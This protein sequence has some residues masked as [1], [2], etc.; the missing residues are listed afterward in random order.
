MTIVLLEQIGGQIIFMK[1]PLDRDDLACG[2]V[3]QTGQESIVIPG[4]QFLPHG[5]TAGLVGL[6]AV[7]DDDELRTKPGDR[8]ANRDRLAH[9]ASGGFELQGTVATVA[10]AGCRKV[11]LVPIALHDPR[12]WVMAEQ[13]GDIGNRGGDRFEVPGRDGDHQ[14]SFAAVMNLDK[15]MADG[16]QVPGRVQGRCSRVQSLEALHHEQQE[17]QS[18][19]GRQHG[20]ALIAEFLEE[21]SYRRAVAQYI[22]IL[23]QRA[24]VSDEELAA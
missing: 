16:L 7:I 6:H 14:P 9:P 24:G 1:A 10:D 21:A 15:R 17:M 3:I 5:R 11:P 2:L 12:G 13:P 8:A 18:A 20:G 23:A 19:R 22:A 4:A